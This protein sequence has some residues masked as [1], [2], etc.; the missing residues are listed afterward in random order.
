[1]PTL[2]ESRKSVTLI[3]ETNKQY[4]TCDNFNQSVKLPEGWQTT[5]L[6]P[7]DLE[8]K[9]YN[10]VVWVDGIHNQRQQ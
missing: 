5:G 4:S 10:L 9:G 7:F 2:R 8:N 6:K 3:N 1:M